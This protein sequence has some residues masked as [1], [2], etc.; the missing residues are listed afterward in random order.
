MGK[1]LSRQEIII[2]DENDNEIGVGEK[3]K[4]HQEGRLHRAFSIFVFN[5]K[6][7]ILL[8]KRARTKYHSPGLWSNSCC[9]HPRP[10]Q[11]LEDEARRRLKEEMGIECNNLKEILS[12]VYR[13]E[14]EDL[15]EHEF[16]HV[17]SGRFDNDPEPNKEEV[18]DWKWVSPEKLKEDIEKNPQNY[19]PWFRIILKRVLKEYE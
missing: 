14:V 10:N 6:G 18:E 8:Q 7:E 4:V 13:A 17:F 16:D 3:L 12:F 15:I 5:Q 11:K 2:V 9:S 1:I 19:T